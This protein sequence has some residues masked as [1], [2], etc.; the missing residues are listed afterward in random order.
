VCFQS[1]PPALEN[2]IASTLNES[3]LSKIK[4]HLLGF[5]EEL[6]RYF[7]DMSN[8]LLPLVKTPFTFQIEVLPETVEDEFIT[9]THNTIVKSGVST[10]SVTQF[11]I[12]LKIIPFATNYTSS[13][14]RMGLRHLQLMT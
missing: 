5:T 11:N 14:M 3:L 4:S 2:E 10:L 12:I 7:L 8:E 1:F 6:S 13:T 9:M